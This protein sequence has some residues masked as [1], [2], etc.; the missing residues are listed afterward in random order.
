MQWQAALNTV[1]F[2]YPLLLKLFLW[3]WSCSLFR[4]ADA[5]CNEFF[6]FHC[7]YLS[8]QDTGK[9]K[10]SCK[11]RHKKLWGNISRF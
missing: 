5:L 3:N 8:P 11:K 7:N 10:L 6:L 1:Y 2:L 4:A 9:E